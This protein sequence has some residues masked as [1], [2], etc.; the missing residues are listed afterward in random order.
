MDSSFYV[1]VF[2]NSSMKFYPDNTILA[3]TVQL[4]HEI[5]LAGAR[6]EVSLCEFSYPPPKV[7]TQKPHALLYDTNA[8]IH[9]ELIATQFVKSRQDSLFKNIY[10]PYGLLQ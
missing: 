4:A 1:T 3:F 2:N 5:D 10:S 7:G 9:C 8:L 6:W